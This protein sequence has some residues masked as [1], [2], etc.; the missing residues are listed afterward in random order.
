M[1]DKALYG[2][3]SSNYR[4]AERLADVL[5]DMGFFP[6]KAEPDIWMRK[7]GDHYEYIAVYVDDLLIASK[8]PMAIIEPLQSVYK[9]KLKGTGEISF[10][11]GMNFAR[12]ESGDPPLGEKGVLSYAPR[13]YLERMFANFER[14]FGHKPKEHRSPL[15]PNDHP[16]LDE[17]E[18]LDEEKIRTYQSLIGT[19]QWLVTIGK[20]DI[21]TAVMTMSA[22][23]SEPRVGHMERLK[24][25]YGFVYKFRYSEIRVDTSFPDFSSL[26]A[27]IH[28][29]DYS[30]YGNVTE[31]LPTDMPEPLGKPVVTVSYV[32]ANLYHDMLS[33]KSVTGIL[34]FLNKTLCDWYC[35]KQATVETATYGSEFSAA[36]TAVEQITDLR[37]TLQYLGV[38]VHEQSHLFGDNKSVVD[39]SSLPGAKL[40][41]RH[42][43]LSFHRV[44]EAIAS[45]MLVF[46]HI[47]GELNPAD[48]L[49]KHWAYGKVWNYIL[50]PLLYFRGGPKMDYGESDHEVDD[51]DG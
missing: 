14:I 27:Q 11:L 8:D 16:E 38:P 35:K 48:L 33:G 47:P 12:D 6:S 5:R 26:P 7:K 40:H 17:S 39:S 29:W 30:V 28:D 32:D 18:F 49:S 44:R 24:R 2:L 3:R 9:F 25:I 4:W 23:R 22:F 37:T 1:I 13:Q 41:K 20:I 51:G 42:T 15:E 43:M 36:R 31:L 50:Q 10:H 46:H 34:H 21:F 19:L 45:G